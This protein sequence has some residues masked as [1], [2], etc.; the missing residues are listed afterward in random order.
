[1]N[2]TIGHNEILN[3]ALQVDP[4]GAQCYRTEAGIALALWDWKD[5]LEEDGG[6]VF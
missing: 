6:E 2:L 1:M 3:M 4:I 5:L